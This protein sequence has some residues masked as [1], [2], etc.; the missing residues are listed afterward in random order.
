MNELVD[1][2]D[3][4]TSDLARRPRRAR[5]CFVLTEKYGDQSEWAAKLAGLTRMQ[6]LDVLNHFE[7]HNDLAERVSSFGVEDLFRLFRSIGGE[8]EVLVASDF[9]FLL[10]AWCHQPS[11]LGQLTQRAEFWSH[12]PA[13]LLV[14]QRR[15]SLADLAYKRHPHRAVIERTDTISLDGTHGKA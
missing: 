13:L 10:S 15:R 9:E 14:T 6:H 5:A 12:R 8:T 4:V 11:F 3:F 2:V 1:I 7:E